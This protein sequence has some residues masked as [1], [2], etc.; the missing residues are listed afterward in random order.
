MSLILCFLG[1][2]LLLK[3]G[4]MAVHPKRKDKRESK[5]NL[6]Q[7][8]ISKLRGLPLNLVIHQIHFVQIVKE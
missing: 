5:K 3:H 1:T 4:K 6:L 8:L 7:V 2:H